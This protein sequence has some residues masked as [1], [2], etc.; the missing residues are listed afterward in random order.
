[1]L[2]ER[3]LSNR[4]IAVVIGASRH[5][6]RRDIQLAQNEPVD[7]PAPQPKPTLGLDGK[8]RMRV[9]TAFGVVVPFMTCSAN[10]GSSRLRRAR[11]VVAFS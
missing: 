9:A 6:V 3:G 7:D 5:T 10:V 4:A 8:T 1:M 11:I 2:A